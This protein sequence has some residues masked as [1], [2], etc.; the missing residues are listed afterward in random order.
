MPNTEFE[1]VD[2][3]DEA[4]FMA[5]AQ[6]FEIGFGD[7]DAKTNRKGKAS[8]IRDVNSALNMNRITYSHIHDNCNPLVL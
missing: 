1:E 6:N 8:T 3:S 2:E 5:D 4:K 7:W